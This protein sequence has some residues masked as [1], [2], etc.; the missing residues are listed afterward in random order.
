MQDM[1]P[2]E[3]EHDELLDTVDEVMFRG[4]MRTGEP[5]P[6]YHEPEPEADLLLELALQVKISEKIITAKVESM[7]QMLLKRMV[8]TE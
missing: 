6:R 3:V 8:A 2:D 1:N 4:Q 7:E 5:Q